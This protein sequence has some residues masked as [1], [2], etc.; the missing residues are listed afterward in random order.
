[1]RK[2]EIVAA[3]SRNSLTLRADRVCVCVRACVRGGVRACVRVRVRVR[4]RMRMRTNERP[5]I[6]VVT[7]LNHGLPIWGVTFCT[8]TETRLVLAETT[9]P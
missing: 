2:I 9:S 7:W 3:V 6:G 4:V 5:C 8:N 1:M